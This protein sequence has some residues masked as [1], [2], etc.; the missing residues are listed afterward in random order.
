MPIVFIEKPN[1]LLKRLAFVRKKLKLVVS[2]ALSKLL[3]S[4]SLF[5]FFSVTASSQTPTGTVTA[6]QYFGDGISIHMDQLA[7]YDAASAVA[8]D[9]RDVYIAAQGPDTLST[10]VCWDTQ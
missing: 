2:L 1:Y 9:A 8:T 7:A 4:L 6:A 3:L 10:R 5:L